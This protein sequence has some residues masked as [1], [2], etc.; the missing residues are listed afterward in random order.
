MILMI[1]IIIIIIIIAIVHEQNVQ[2]KHWL[3]AFGDDGEKQR[4]IVTHC[5]GGIRYG[6]K[7]EPWQEVARQRIRETG[8]RPKGRREDKIILPADTELVIWQKRQKE[9]QKYNLKLMCTTM[10]CKNVKNNVFYKSDSAY[11]FKIILCPFL[12]AFLIFSI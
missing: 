6:R 1:K 8:T 11:T 5:F 10:T 9:P 12:T 3:V 7:L 4:Y 2:V